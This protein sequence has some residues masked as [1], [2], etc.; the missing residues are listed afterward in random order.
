MQSSELA[1]RLR[2]LREVWAQTLDVSPDDIADTADFFDLGGDSMLALE[3]A[4]ESRQA[5]LE[6][7]MSA[8]LRRPVLADL[9]AAV[10]D[11]RLFALPPGADSVAISERY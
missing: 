9:A 5:G 6:M 10:L 11:P 7:P 8:V 2:Q 1:V 3:A 4:T